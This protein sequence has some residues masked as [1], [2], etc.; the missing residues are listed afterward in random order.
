M[1]AVAGDLTGRA[2]VLQDVA[3]FFKD[4]GTTPT[5]SSSRK[6]DWTA[7]ART[8]IKEKESRIHKVEAKPS[9]KGVAIEMSTES[10]EE[11]ERY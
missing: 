2:E 11:F 7:V 5:S 10:D 4:R 9:A 1:A 8:P 6:Q 3:A